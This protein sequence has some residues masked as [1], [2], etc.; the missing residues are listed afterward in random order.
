MAGDG[1]KDFMLVFHS[2]YVDLIRR[3]VIIALSFLLFESETTFDLFFY[4]G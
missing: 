2:Q 4:M 1:I 3:T